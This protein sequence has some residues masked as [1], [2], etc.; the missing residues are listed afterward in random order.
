MDEPKFQTV[1]NYLG[2]LKQE[3]QDEIVDAIWDMDTTVAMTKKMK[4]WKQ[5]VIPRAQ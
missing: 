3:L 5:Y 4:E 1:T 2:R